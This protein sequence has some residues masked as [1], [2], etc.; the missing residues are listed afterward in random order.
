[1][2]VILTKIILAKEE[3]RISQHS[4]EVAD[5]EGDWQVGDVEARAKVLF[6]SGIEGYKF[7]HNGFELSKFFDLCDLDTESDDSDTIY[8]D[9]FK[10]EYEDN[11]PRDEFPAKN[12]TQGPN[13]IENPNFFLD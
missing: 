12:M 10:E 11:V 2:K 3:G 5:A 9:L 8:L 13:S 6:E 1:M 7:F 4:K